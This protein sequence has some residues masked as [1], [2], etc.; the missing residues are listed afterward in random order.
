[1]KKSISDVTIPSTLLCSEDA[2]AHV[3]QYG[4]HFDKELWDRWTAANDTVTGTDMIKVIK[5]PKSQ[6]TGEYEFCGLKMAPTRGVPKNQRLQYHV[7]RK[8]YKYQQVCSSPFSTAAPTQPPSNGLPGPSYVECRDA[9]KPKPVMCKKKKG[10][11]K[12][13]HTRI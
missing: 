2:C 7:L 3:V 1:M 4:K 5:Y 11:K 6:L 12:I 8:C 10:D 13:S 9:V